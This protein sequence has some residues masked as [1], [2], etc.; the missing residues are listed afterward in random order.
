MTFYLFGAGVYCVFL[1]LLIF[2]NQ[3]NLNTAPI[4]WLIIFIAST[5]WVFVIPISLLE[6]VIKVIKGKSKPY[7]RGKSRIAQETP[8]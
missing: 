8:Q 6:M 4:S 5:F 2:K 3:Q 7:G 1:L